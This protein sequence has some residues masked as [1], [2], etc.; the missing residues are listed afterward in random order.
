MFQISHKNKQTNIKPRENNANI[1]HIRMNLKPDKAYSFVLKA[2]LYHHQFYLKTHNMF[3]VMGS[4]V[5]FQSIP[6]TIFS[7]E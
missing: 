5:Y 4:V 2:K 7:N 1:R 3:V 6:Q